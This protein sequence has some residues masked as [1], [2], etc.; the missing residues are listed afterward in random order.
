M[1]DRKALALAIAAGTTPRFIEIKRE[2][3]SSV[4]HRGGTHPPPPS[5]PSF[6]F[7]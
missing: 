4:L 5:K 1:S 3:L 2:K 7:G 6:D